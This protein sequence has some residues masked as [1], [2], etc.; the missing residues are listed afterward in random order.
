MPTKKQRRRRA[1]TFRHEYDF[2][3]EDEEGN[4]V[5]VES[6]ELRAERTQRTAA[7]P[8]KAPSR[9]G[10][11]KR[12]PA[13]A[14]WHRAF[15]RG[16][17]MGALMLAAFLFLFKSAPIGVR[18]AWGVFYAAAFVPLTYVIDRTAYRS[19]QKRLAR[20]SDK[21]PKTKAT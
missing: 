1:K 14:S 8:T 10:R 19:Y 3:I 16:G 5:P 7:K 13:P 18:V 15:R 2:V 11:S 4:E 12:E 17:I 20:T 9:G 21:K 6:S